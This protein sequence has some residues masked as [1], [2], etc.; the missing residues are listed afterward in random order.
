MFAGIYLWEG[1]TAFERLPRGFPWAKPV[2][3]ADRILVPTK[4]C[5]PATFASSAVATVFHWYEATR[6]GTEVVTLSLTPQWRHFHGQNA[7]LP[8][9]VTVKVMM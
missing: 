1:D 9:R 6:A 7:P 3:S 5:P 2:L 4:E 8:V